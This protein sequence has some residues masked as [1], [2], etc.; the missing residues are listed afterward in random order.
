MCLTALLIKFIAVLV[1]TL[2]VL[3]N[4]INSVSVNSRSASVVSGLVAT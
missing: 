3:I 2:A 4:G 1:S